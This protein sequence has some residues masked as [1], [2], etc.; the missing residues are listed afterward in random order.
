MRQKSHKRPLTAAQSCENCGAA[1]ET[2]RVCPSCG[3]YKGRQVLTID[4]KE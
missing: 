2:H 3:Y 4:S 1:R